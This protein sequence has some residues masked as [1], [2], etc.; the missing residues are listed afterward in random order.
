LQFFIADN[1]V[2]AEHTSMTMYHS[3]AIKDQQ[4][5]ICPRPSSILDQIDRLK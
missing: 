5:Q 4:T 1:N 3:T 2:S